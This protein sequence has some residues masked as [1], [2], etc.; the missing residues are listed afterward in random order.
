[1]II[2]NEFFVFKN[3]RAHIDN[4][5]FILLLMLC[6]CV[7][8][9]IIIRIE[10]GLKTVDVD[11]SCPWKFMKIILEKA[12]LNEMALFIRPAHR[13]FYFYFSQ[14]YIH[15]YIRSSKKANTFFEVFVI[16][17]DAIYVNDVIINVM[18]M[19]SF[20]MPGVSFICCCCYV[21]FFCL[22]ISIVHPFPSIK[23]SVNFS[24][25]LTQPFQLDMS[26]HFV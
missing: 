3:T 21:F 13:L 8:P 26:M 17:F 20:P 11:V 12:N 9:I 18:S 23:S 2:L 1:M 16:K 6:A 5:S 4:I 25:P 15:G 22:S 24:K 14:R 19:V 10:T 7:C